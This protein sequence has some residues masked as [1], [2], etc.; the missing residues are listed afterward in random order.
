MFALIFRA[1]KLYT[2]KTFKKQA[3]VIITVSNKIITLAK[4][5]HQ[6]D[7]VLQDI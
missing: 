3:P 5:E 2:I 4:L 6:R 7:Y 1:M